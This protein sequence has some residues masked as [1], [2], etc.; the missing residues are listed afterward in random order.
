[1]EA[2][3]RERRAHFLHVSLVSFNL[4]PS[5]RSSSSSRSIHQSFPPSP[6]WRNDGLLSVPPTGDLFSMRISAGAFSL[7][8]F[9][10]LL[11]AF[12]VIVSSDIA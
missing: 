12:I 5:F 3:E 7:S 1:M 6:L 2:K 11:R 8:Y 9:L 4:G 10:S